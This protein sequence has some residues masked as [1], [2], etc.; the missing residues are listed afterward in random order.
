MNSDD[1]ILKNYRV[2]LNR[3]NVA[4]ELVMDSLSGDN[5]FGKFL[6]TSYEEDS[7]YQLLEWLKKYNLNL[8]VLGLAYSSIFNKKKYYPQYSNLAV[9]NDI[10]MRNMMIFMQAIHATRCAVFYNAAS[11]SLKI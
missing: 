11:I 4:E 9:P 1:I 2:T 6:L 10:L 8:P 7:V 5:P 3:V